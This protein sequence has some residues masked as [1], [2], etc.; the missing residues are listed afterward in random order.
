VFRLHVVDAKH[1]ISKPR[2]RKHIRICILSDVAMVAP[3]SR[4]LFQS[5][6]W[7]SLIAACLTG[8]S[9]DA[10]T[11]A[12]PGTQSANSVAS[13]R[14][15]ALPSLGIDINQTSVSGISSGAY[16]AGQFQM[17]H[18]GI[19]V[20][21]GIVA[22]GPYGCAESL[23]GAFS[24]GFARINANA[25]QAALGCMANR[26][27]L[28]GVPNAS[29]LA[30]RAVRLAERGRID[31][32][33]QVQTDRVFL[34]SGTND[35]I[36]LPPIVRSAVA[37]YRALGV[38]EGNIELIDT[39]AAG[40][41]FV[42]QRAEQACE[43]NGSPYLVNCNYDLAGAILAHIYGDLSPAGDISQ[44][45]FIAFD[46]SEFVEAASRH[47]LD[48]VGRAFVP[49][50]CRTAPGGSPTC[51]VHV[52]YH[53][54]NQGREIVGDRFVGRSGFARWAAT[55]RLVVLFPQIKRSALNLQ[56]CWDWWGY[57]G[58][59]FLTR[60]APQI[61]AVYSMLERLAGKR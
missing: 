29:R 37:F 53:G 54:C 28:Y 49:D 30:E 52:A 32:V 3:F 58:R 25:T 34:F 20:G 42:S 43:R 38:P 40:H 55:N 2:R 15:V 39:T 48:R 31:P 1:W 10:A 24:L 26:M 45:R 7:L 22:G 8:L 57:T 56:G 44:G 23:A 14:P 46:Q 9:R 35:A 36:V 18:A 16:M 19:V 47:G 27:A 33:A 12:S 60:R 11:A 17:A 6:I 59:N 61:T 5:A 21:A 50:A 51:R 13:D 4:R 41:G